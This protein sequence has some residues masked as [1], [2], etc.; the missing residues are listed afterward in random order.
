MARNKFYCITINWLSVMNG[1][2]ITITPLELI[3]LVNQTYEYIASQLKMTDD[4]VKLVALTL[5]EI[6]EKNRA[7]KS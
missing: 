3:K 2:H 4:D 5:A 7:L 6:I 1:N